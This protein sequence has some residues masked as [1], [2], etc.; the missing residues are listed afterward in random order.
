MN[1]EGIDREIL[2][3]LAGQHRSYFV[4]GLHSERLAQAGLNEVVLYAFGTHAGSDEA[5]KWR[6]TRE[7]K[8]HEG[9]ADCETSRHFWR[10]VC[11]ARNLE[12][13]LHFSPKPRGKTNT[14]GSRYA[15]FKV[16]GTPLLLARLYYFFKL[17]SRYP[18]VATDYFLDQIDADKGFVQLNGL[19]A[20][21]AVYCLYQGASIGARLEKAADIMDWE[22][23][24]GWGVGDA[25]WGCHKVRHHD[26][27][28]LKPIPPNLFG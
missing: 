8:R 22:P 21:K 28:A 17:Y 11:E 19:Q 24:T 2:E 18:E 7:V 27:S 25:E 14:E 23:L 15:R 13:G 3:D 20:Q 12:I 1:L 16:R 4:S 6:E 10:G 5:E 9:R 26:L